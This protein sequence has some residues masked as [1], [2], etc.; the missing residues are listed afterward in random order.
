MTGAYNADSNVTRDQMAAFIARAFL[1]N[2]N[3]SGDNVTINSVTPESAVENQSTAFAVDVS[4][5]L[6]SIDSG[7]LMVGFNTNQVDSYAMM[8]SAMCTVS[9]GSGT[10]VFNVTATPI[11]WGSAGSFGAYVNLVQNPHPSSFTPL[12]FDIKPISISSSAAGSLSSVNAL[13]SIDAPVQC[14]DDGCL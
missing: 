7:L 8:S 3:I 5:T 2:T 10:H 1:R 11:N 6:T 13:M 4:Y 9:R 12:V 14:N